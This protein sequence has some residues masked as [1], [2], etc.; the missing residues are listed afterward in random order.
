VEIKR[1][2]DSRS[3]SLV[4]TEDLEA[5]EAEFDE[6]RE[7]LE[8]LA[9]IR[10]LEQR[11]DADSGNRTPVEDVIRDLGFADLLSEATS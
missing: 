5:F 7:T 11:V 1:R 3:A 9:I 10:L 4:A 2:G 8:D 6:M